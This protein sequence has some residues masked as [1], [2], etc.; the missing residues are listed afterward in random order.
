MRPRD[1][2]RGVALILVLVILPLVAILMTQLN[3]E[4]A[5]GTRLSSNALATQQF[6]AATLARLRQMRLRLKRDLIDDEANAQEAGGAFDHPNDMWGPAIDGGGT[7]VMVQMGPGDNVPGSTED[8]TI[9]IYTQVQDEHGKFNINNLQHRDTA[10]ARIWQQRFKTLLD[11]YRDNAYGDL[12]T[13]EY[14]LSPQEAEE[15]MQAVL[16]FLKG[17]D[18]N[19]LVRKVELPDASAELPQTI[20]TVRDLV[21]SHR[22]FAEKRL[23]ETFVDLDTGARILGLEELLTVY[24]D[25]KINVNTA[26]VQVLRACFKDDDARRETAEAIFKQRGGYL[27]TTEERQRREEDI[28]EREEAEEDGAEDD[29]A[30]LENVFKTLNDLSQVENMGDGAFLR[31]NEIDS[32][33]DFTVRSNFFRVI[34]TARRENYLRQ[35]RVV[36]ERHT[37]GCIT[38]FSEVRSAEIDDLPELFGGE[39]PE[40]DS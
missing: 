7:T 39:E 28:A 29:T 23:L 14:D 22:L 30:S 40:I 21:F 15:I 27:E 33:A 32:Q 2:E 10:R 13:G 4:T 37:Q 24:G 5:I 3:F 19:E 35:Q 36:F 34:V 31:R 38:W 6:R 12:E 17:D 16:K 20:F 1:G 25:G 8:D 9:S 11:I 18:R 26:P